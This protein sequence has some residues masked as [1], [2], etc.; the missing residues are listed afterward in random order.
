M[1]DFSSLI[2]GVWR[3]SRRKVEIVSPYSGAVVG[4]V[5]EASAAQVETA[6]ESGK[7]A[8]LEMAALP[9]HRRRA[10]LNGIADILRRR[11]TDF[12]ML[13]SSEAGKPIA[14]ARAEVQRAQ[15]TFAFAAEEVPRL[16]G[17]SIDL[18]SAVP[19]QGRF[20]IVRRFPVGLIAAITPF[21]FPLNLVA[22]KVAPAIAAGCP[23]IVK[24][25]PQAPL[26][27]F[28]LAQACLDAGIP[29]CGLSVVLCRVEDAEPLVVDPRV[30]LLTFTGSAA[31]G[32][33]LK[34]AAGHKRVLLELGGNAAAIVH[35][36]A[37]I[38]FAASRIAQGAFAYAGQSCIS[39]QRVLVHRDRWEAFQAALL[40]RIAS[41]VATGDPSD[42]SV[43]C[44][45]VIDATAAERI[46]TWTAEAVAGGAQL[47]LSGDRRGLVLQPAVLTN[48]PRHAHLN[49]AEAFG[50]VVTLAPY[51]ALTTALTE[52][53]DSR[54][55]LQAGIFTDSLAALWQTYETLQVGAVI[56]NDVPTF[57]VDHMPYGGVKDSGLGR[58][59]PHETM[60]EYTEPRLLALRP[61]TPK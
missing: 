11:E 30:R 61:L 10:I 34:A 6:I 32:W 44:G 55:G 57:R 47:L 35:D 54:Y 43:L 2:D 60:L 31:V 21:N 45:P 49:W 13:L 50:P 29:P 9:G 12:A 33:Q 51:D 52:V 41:D 40:E 20:G 16:C 8:C 58:E 59:G 1:H 28:A 7:A 22:H 4:T 46:E 14:L 5:H 17:E 18:A 24:P 25:A 27:A 19:G 48:V 53:N 23:I 26:S 37:D 3:Q 36:D 39:V 56:H 38:A 42:A 15:D